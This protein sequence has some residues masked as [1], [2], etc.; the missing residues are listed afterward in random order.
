[1][2]KNQIDGLFVCGHTVTPDNTTT[3]DMC[4]TCKRKQDREH[5]H[6]HRD[7][8]VMA[9]RAWWKTAKKDIYYRRK[10]AKK[11][12]L[13]VPQYEQMF[14]DQNNQCAICKTVG[15]LGVDHNHQTGQVRQLL[16]ENCNRGIGLFREDPERLRQAAAYCEAY[17][18]GSRKVS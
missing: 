1:M 11:Y 6:R 2:P 3:N 10:I 15:K 16:C 8:R 13:T 4:R 14:V 5:H 7:A 18:V 17:S 9:S 12:G